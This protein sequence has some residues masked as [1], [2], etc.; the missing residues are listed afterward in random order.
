MGIKSKWLA[1]NPVSR[2]IANEKR[3]KL[4]GNEISIM[5]SNCLGGLLYHTYGLKFLSPLV[6]T[7]INSNEFVKLI[8]NYKET[9]NL[10]LHFI[11]SSNPF[12][13][14]KLNDIIVN[15]VHYH[16]V[17]EAELKWYD[18]IKRINEEHL[19]VILNDNDGLTE[20]DLYALD[21]CPIQNIL[22]FTAKKYTNH[23]CT[24]WL[25][26][27]EGQDYV[28]NTMRKDWIKGEMLVEKYFDFAGWFQQKKGIN[29][30]NYRLK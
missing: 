1:I 25:P 3:Q 4:K 26:P 22:V 11:H 30:E 28:G 7:R 14:A 19:F 9:I 10:P 12:P 23:R 8:L 21:H 18:R 29:L 6:N 27:F 24:F 17:K 5:A 16:N 13:V 20:D 2:H 15:F